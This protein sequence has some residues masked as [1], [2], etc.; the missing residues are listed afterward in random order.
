MFL[1]VRP[2]ERV[3][4]ERQRTAGRLTAAGEGVKED[5][6]NQK[7]TLNK[8]RN[9]VEIFTPPPA[10][11][12]LF[13]E[14]THTHGCKSRDGGAHLLCVCEVLAKHVFVSSTESDVF[15]IKSCVNLAHLRHGS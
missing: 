11:V 4:S 2:N 8:H 13:T 6:K 7:I 5:M 12:K 3:Q 9:P 10:L 1:D 14:H 15:Q